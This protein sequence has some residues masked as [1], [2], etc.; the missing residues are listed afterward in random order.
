MTETTPG[1]G[2]LLYAMADEHAR[3]LVDRDDVLEGML[4]RDWEAVQRQAQTDLAAVTARMDAARATG[5]P[6]SPAW[7]YQER[8]FHDLLATVEQQ[9]ALYGHG[10]TQVTTDAQEWAAGRGVDD[11]AASVAAAAGLRVDALTPPPRNVAVAAGF[12]TD[13]SPLSDLFATLGPDAV[14]HAREAL[15]TAAAMGW[16]AD[17]TARALR[18]GLAVTGTRAVTIARTEVHRVYRESSRTL[19]QANRDVVTGWTWRAALDRRC[20]S[21]CM[22][23][24]GTAHGVDDTLD[25]HPRC[26]C[27]MVPL[28]PSWADLGVEDVADL[29][30]PPQGR[31][32]A[33]LAAMSPAEQD[34]ALGP[35]R[36]ALYRQGQIGLQDMVVRTRDPRWGS[37]RREATVL[38]ARANAAAR[39]V[40]QRVVKT[41]PR[42][43]TQPARRKTPAEV[44]T[45]T[46]ALHDAKMAAM[47]A[48]LDAVKAETARVVAARKAV[49]AQF[50][51]TMADPPSYQTDRYRKARDTARR[52][53]DQ[54]KADRAAW[55]P[56]E[57]LD[58]AMAE[59][60]QFLADRDHGGDWGM[61]MWASMSDDAWL[62]LSRQRAGLKTRQDLDDSLRRAQVRYDREQALLDRHDAPRTY[63]LPDTFPRFTPA[64]VPDHMHQEVNPRVGETIDWE[65]NCSRTATTWELRRRGYDVTAKSRDL[66]DN[67]TD[68][69]GAM[70]RRRDGSLPQ[71]AP[72][73]GERAALA[74]LSHWP[75]GARGFVTI[76]WE[77]GGGHIY[78]VEVVGGVPRFFE[79]QVPPS[80]NPR[81]SPD[82]YLARARTVQILRTDELVPTSGLADWVSPR[83]Q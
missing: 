73:P 60:T 9:T 57:D 80:P 31:A 63:G 76:V 45:E 81:H 21:G 2:G 69:I 56:T 70:W 34:R 28:T 39:G 4:A 26:R 38:E 16:G 54:A 83:T 10:A 6:I 67:S 12:L 7:L 65:V 51:R 79:G 49:E 22:A 82:G 37:M 50:P 47:R 55:V 33:R 53:L 36:A 68:L 8:R 27:A 74:H 3:R 1:L 72:L 23:M 59:R 17:R 71:W 61:G 19:Y 52:D 66:D 64:A 11:A 13:G 43:G 44:R 46:R 42:R 15:V 78:N 32:E 25:G 29:P 75:E 62:T 30:G 58:R 48:E 5:K 24:D 14:Q 35:A 77:G 18:D 40:R 20:C 41:T